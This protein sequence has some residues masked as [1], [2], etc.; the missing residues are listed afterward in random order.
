MDESAGLGAYRELIL[1]VDDDPAL[2]EML[3]IVLR[4]EGFETEWCATGDQALGA[5]IQ[6]QP[7]LVLL[8]VMLPGLDGIRVCRQI[9][10]LSGVPI[11]MLSARSDTVDVVRGL[12]RR[13]RL[14]RQTLQGQNWWPVRASCVPTPASSKTPANSCASAT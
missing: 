11:I 13:R 12:R 14:H 7:A 1:V 2:A 10:E 4:Q 9:R 8:D 5:F 6:T 3:Q